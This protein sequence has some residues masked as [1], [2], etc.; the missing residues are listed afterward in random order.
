MSC[1]TNAVAFDTCSDFVSYLRGGPPTEKLL[2]GGQ[3]KVSWCCS[4][5][6]LFAI[7]VMLCGFDQKYCETKSNEA[8]VK[9]NRRSVTAGSG[10]GY[11]GGMSREPVRFGLFQAVD[12]KK[13][14]AETAEKKMDQFDKLILS[15]LA[16]LCPSPGNDQN[17]T[18][19]L[20]SFDVQPPRAFVSMLVNSK[21]LAK[22]AELLRNDSLE[23]ATQRRDLY[24]ALID[25]LKRVA[26]HEVSKKDVMYSERICQPNTVDLL[27]I[28][29]GGSNSTTAVSSTSSSL[30]ECLRKLNIQ[31]DMMMQNAQRLRHE[32]KD[33]RG[34]DM[35]WLCR[36]ISD[37]SSYLR[38]EQWWTQ[39][40]CADTAQVPD[41]GIIE[42]PDNEIG[43]AFALMGPAQALT[44]SPPGRIRRL[45]TEI[46]S[47]K[48]GLS[49][50]I[51]VKHAMSRPDMMK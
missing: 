4:R 50:G 31:S 41:H 47:L 51:Y 29:F 14:A 30:A 6:R 5:G 39:N 27:Y 43:V 26:V 22:A 2:N 35:L 46:T 45:I 18:A 28:S 42:V 13:N 21:I 16:V 11:A 36:E 19:P 48:T 33:Q 38:I 15:F 37:L 3:N 1:T 32:F 34:Q 44:Q 23:N 20:T 9:N 17:D 25:F 40:N 12:P 10:V 8:S 7:F 24:M 49:S